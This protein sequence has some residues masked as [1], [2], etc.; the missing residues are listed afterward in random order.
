MKR[1]SIYGFTLIE[2]MIGI[3]AANGALKG[4]KGDDGPSAP[5]APTPPDDFGF[6]HRAVADR[7]A[8]RPRIHKDL[9]RRNPQVKRR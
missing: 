1:A 8:R 9:I 2:M 5:T 6:H 4:Q 3:G 7:H